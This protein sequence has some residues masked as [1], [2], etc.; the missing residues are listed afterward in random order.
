VFRE[1]LPIYGNYGDVQNRYIDNPETLVG[2]PKSDFFFVRFL[3]HFIMIRMP[4]STD[5]SIIVLL[6]KLSK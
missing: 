2:D 3:G 4:N 1:E 6:V 5:K